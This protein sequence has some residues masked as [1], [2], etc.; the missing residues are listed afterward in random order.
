MAVRPMDEHREASGGGRTDA[1]QRAAHVIAEAVR[2]ARP[3][4]LPERLCAAAVA[5]LPVTGASASLHSAGLPVRVGASS[6]RAA[7]LTELQ[8]S[9]GDG[10]CLSAVE[11][12]VPVLAGDLTGGRDA[13][14][15]P[16]FAH[17]ALE[18]GTRAAYSIPLGNDSVCV[19]TLDLYRD[20]P[21]ELTAGELHTAELVAGVM[22]VALMALPHEEDGALDNARWLNGLAADH[23]EVHQ[24]TGMIM[25]QLGVGPDEALARLRAHAFARGRTVLDAAGDVVEHRVRF[26][27]D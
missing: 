19:G 25:V 27:G 15:W 8:A 7:L 16:M 26:D 2:N 9:L 4:D 3:R 20:T 24:A 17:E 13:G 10:P 11:T 22:T 14:R 1:R 6:D 18:A 23:D 5:L 12:G 21:G